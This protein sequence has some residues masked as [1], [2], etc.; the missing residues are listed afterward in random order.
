MS[1]WD[2]SDYHTC[3]SATVVPG[4]DLGIFP[5]LVCESKMVIT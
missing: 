4:G 2:G 1:I 3:K 5:S